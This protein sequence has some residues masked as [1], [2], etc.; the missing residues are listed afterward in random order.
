MLR[1]KNT[2]RR[3]V[4]ELTSNNLTKITFGAGVSDS[5]DEVI[6]PNPDNVGSPL[7]TGVNKLDKGFDPANFLYTKSYGQVPQSTTLTVTYSRGGGIESNVPQGDI[8]ELV[9]FST[10][11]D[12]A[13]IPNISE[14]NN[15]VSSVAVTNLIPAT[16][17]KGAESIEELKF[18]ALASFPAQNR[19]VTKVDY[20]VRCYSLPAKYGNVCKVYIAPDEQLNKKDGVVD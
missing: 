4:S 11:N 2:A 12:Q 19:A 15:A 16:G 10:L 17:G 14:F 3:F 8:T 5:P 7:G 6:T 1:V 20:I 13:S 9:S 18:N